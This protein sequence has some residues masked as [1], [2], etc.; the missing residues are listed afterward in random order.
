M[1]GV[2]GSAMKVRGAKMEG[3][4]GRGRDRKVENWKRG[5][6]ERAKGR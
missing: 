1:G 2:T 5:R 4:K 3:K 6:K